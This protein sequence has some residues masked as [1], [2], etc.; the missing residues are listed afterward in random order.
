VHDSVA[1]QSLE[2]NIQII[3]PLGIK[4][5]GLQSGATGEG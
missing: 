4:L 1:E 3:E 5:R 2:Q